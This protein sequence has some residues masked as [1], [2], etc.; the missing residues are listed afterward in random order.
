MDKI[1]HVKL[2]KEVYYNLVE[3][4]G[5]LRAKDWK[6]FMEKVVELARSDE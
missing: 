3:M 1:L 5:R 4:K 6:E 2:P